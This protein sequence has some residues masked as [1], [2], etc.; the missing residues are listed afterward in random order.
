MPIEWGSALG[1]IGGS[2]V[3]GLFGASQQS[4]AARYARLQQQRNFDFQERMS[5]TAWQRGVKD[6]RAAGINPL[7]AATQGGASSPSG[8]TAGGPGM[9]S[10]PPVDFSAMAVQRQQKKL[11]KAQTAKTGFEAQV[12]QLMAIKTG[13]DVQNYLRT[14]GQGSYQLG[15]SKDPMDMKAL[16]LWQKKDL[17]WQVALANQAAEMMKGIFR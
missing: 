15:K 2:L 8:G 17:G 13:T 14:Y 4:S 6:M 3:S 11:L 12:A 7:L 9:A 1:N 10:L 16:A 5:N